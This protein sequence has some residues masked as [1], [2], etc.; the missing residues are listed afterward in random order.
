MKNIILALG[1][2]LLGESSAYAGI[3]G[4]WSI[5]GTHSGGVDCPYNDNLAY[6]WIV[7]SNNGKVK[8]TVVGETKW[9]ELTGKFDGSQ[10]IVS[11]TKAENSFSKKK[12]HFALKVDGNS[13]SGER[14]YLSTSLRMCTYDIT[15]TKL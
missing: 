5:T 1:L 11:A 9:P 13:L 2:F 6:Q 4:T 8:I 12:T 3:T 15:G 14:T 10:L 7:V